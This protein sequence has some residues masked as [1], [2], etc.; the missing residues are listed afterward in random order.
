MD[1]LV[2]RFKRH[3]NIG[4]RLLECPECKEI[5]ERQDIEDFTNCPYCLKDLPYNY[6]LED[7]LLDPL[8]E[9]WQAQEQSRDELMDETPEFTA[10][11]VI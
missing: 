8:V 2:Y 7:Y 10:N 1:K 6:E 4:M 9:M 11:L 3:S 5:L